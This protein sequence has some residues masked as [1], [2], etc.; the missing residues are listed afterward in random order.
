MQR[1]LTYERA[2]P[3]LGVVRP[4]QTHP[5][6]NRKTVAPRAAMLETDQNIKQSVKKG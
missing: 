2:A 1:S 5:R 4:L 6:A 3:T